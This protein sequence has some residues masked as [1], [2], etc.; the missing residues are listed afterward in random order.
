MW[1]SGGSFIVHYKDP[2]LDCRKESL[3]NVITTLAHI[4]S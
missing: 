2:S 3:A 1:D 4:H